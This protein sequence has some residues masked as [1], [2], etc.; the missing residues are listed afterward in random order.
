MS[1]SRATTTPPWIP[2]GLSTLVLLGL[3]VVLSL[4]PSQR[5]HSGTPTTT[6]PNTPS[7][8][9]PPERFITKILWRTTTTVR[10][11]PSDG[12]SNE[13]FAVTFPTVTSGKP[14]S[15]TIGGGQ[16]DISMVG[17]VAGQH[18]HVTMT[19]LGV[20]NL[21]CGDEAIPVATDFVVPNATL[22]CPLELSG[23]PGTA[24]KVEVMS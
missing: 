4:T 20:L 14:A 10:Q 18:V 15:G 22:L 16:F 12:G 9:L 17:V 8:T 5:H 24:W 2:V 7:S 23:I 3:V 13:S 21:R 6:T 19:P 1:Q 11:L